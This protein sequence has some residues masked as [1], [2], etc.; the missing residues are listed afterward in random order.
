MNLEQQSAANIPP[1]PPGFRIVDPQIPPPPPGFKI[2]DPQPGPWT[3]Y[4]QQPPPPPPGFQI[5]EPSLEDLIMAEPAAFGPDGIPSVPFTDAIGPEPADERS[6]VRRALDFVVGDDPARALRIG[7]QGALRGTVADIAG[8]PVDLTTALMNAGVDVVGLGARAV[9]AENPLGYVNNPFMGSDWIAGVGSDVAEA[10]GVPVEDPNALTGIDRLGYNVNRFS[11]GAGAGSVGLASRA[12]RVAAPTRPAESG[13]ERSLDA[14]TAPYRGRGQQRTVA[15]DVGGG[16]GAG[17]GLTAAQNV[18]VEN[19]YGQA[20]LET[21]AMLGGGL[22]GATAATGVT[23][24][25]DVGR[26]SEVMAPDPNIPFR[27]GTQTPTS[28]RV[29]DK[30]A[31]LVQ[32]QAIDPGVASQV[33][34][35]R[36][37]AA[38]AS[39]D[40]MP[41]TGIGSDDLGLIGLER[42]LRGDP[43]LS[44]RF[45][46]SDEALQTG[47]AERVGALRDPDADV[48]A[49]AREAQSQIDTQLGAAD[50]YVAAARANFEQAEA[51]LRAVQSGETRGQTI[52]SALEDAQ[53]AAREV[54]SA[55]WQGVQGQADPAPLAAS[56]QAVTDSL[57]LGRQDAVSGLR[58]TLD[59]PNRLLARMENGGTVSLEEITSMRSRLTTAQRQAKVAGDSDLANVINRYVR[60][61]DGYLDTSPALS[62]ALASARAVS[63][64]LNDRFTRRGSAV[65][66][67]LASRS[68]G[69]PAMPDSR[70]APRFVQP[71]RGQASELDNLLR[72]AGET[73][74][75]GAGRTGSGVGAP[76]MDGPGNLAGAAPNNREAVREALRDQ[77]LSD[78]QR[79]GLLNNPDRLN[80]Y[81]SEYGQVFS[82]FPDLR[83]EL[84]TAAGLRRTLSEAEAGAAALTRELNNPRNV[85]RMVGSEAD[86]RN[87]ANRVFG[88]NAF[89]SEDAVRQ[90]NDALRGNPEAMRGWKAAVSDMLNARVTRAA[91]GE[92]NPA[93]LN[94]IYQ[95]H[96]AALAEIYTP[97]EMAALD[98]ANETLAPLA[99]LSRGV[100]GGTTSVPGTE[101]YARMEGALLAAGQNA[102]TTGMIVKRIKTAARLLGLENLTDEYKVAQVVQMMQFN[103]ELA[104]HLLERPVSEGVSAA[105]NQRLQNI[106]ATGQ[107]ARTVGDRSEDEPSLEDMIMR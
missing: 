58:D 92:L 40:P 107:A 55:A 48:R 63:R 28:V 43:A 12:N 99:N 46:A 53:R 27:P 67:A 17:A 49:P 29:A 24:A 60:A 106:L 21:G 59:I 10:L 73:V 51:N 72:E 36:L 90:I 45:A 54:E 94:R 11:A 19:P 42:Q 26:L 62:E 2:V 105:W 96:R 70:V 102:V 76:R 52:R 34:N 74:T 44:S 38:R 35:R 25:Y 64:D 23:R 93:E 5:V 61:V 100:R 47:A 77:I 9:G 101:I 31:N 91:D 1:P 4:Q 3:R 78:V 65:A 66:D 37:D 83:Q 15:G 50:A 16:A 85:L 88:G 79:R 69:G 18:D 8:M 104:I 87:L 32:G 39:G 33:L 84:G 71:D 13:I 95:R 81:L 103:P 80:E 86:A 75:P 6:P 7:A 82:R 98:R 22:T 68:G 57:P 20:L 30:A 89:G 97:R 41:T 56:I 14:L